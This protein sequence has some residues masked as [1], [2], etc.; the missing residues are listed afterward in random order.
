MPLARPRD[1]IRA[2]CRHVACGR[3]RH[4]PALAT[5]IALAERDD[6]P[7]NVQLH[8]INSASAIGGATAW[9]ALSRL[10]ED[11]TRMLTVRHWATL[12]LR[13]IKE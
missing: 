3:A 8:C 6:T 7:A 1:F 9:L 4:A 10:A 2:R 12:A 11:T 13:Q 5:L